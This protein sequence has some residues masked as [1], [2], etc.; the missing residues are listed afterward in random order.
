[1]N[2]ARL[3]II[4]GICFALLKDIEIIFIPKCEALKMPLKM[5]YC[6]FKVVAHCGVDLGKY[7]SSLAVEYC[8]ISHK[9]LSREKK[10]PKNISGIFIRFYDRCLHVFFKS[11]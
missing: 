7:H 1:M 2:S 6:F 3:Y 10:S 9:N 4:L 8:I 11:F 5:C